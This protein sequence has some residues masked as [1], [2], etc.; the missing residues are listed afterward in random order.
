MLISTVPGAFLFTPGHVQARFS[1]RS[2]RCHLLRHGLRRVLGRV[3]DWLSTERNVDWMVCDWLFLS[4]NRSA[5][6][7]NHVAWRSRDHFLRKAIAPKIRGRRP[8]F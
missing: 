4:A 2:D 7:Q 6:R 8:W 5:N 3:L 1:V